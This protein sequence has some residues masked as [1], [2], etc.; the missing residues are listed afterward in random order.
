M[1]TVN[2]HIEAQSRRLSVHPFFTDLRPQPSLQQALVFA[3][4]LSPWVMSFQDV[5]RINAD[6]AVEPT[7]RRQLKQHAAEDQGHEAWFLEDLRMLFGDRTR[8]VAWLFGQETAVTR[9]ATLAIA[10]EAFRIGDDRLRLV[11]IDAI[12]AASHTFIEHVHRHVQESGDA[13]QLKYFGRT[14]E[15]AEAAHEMR[16]EGAE[17]HSPEM[18]LPASV[19]S[20]AIALV[21]RVFAEFSRMAESA[22]HSSSRTG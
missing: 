22:R 9:A 1:R 13:A 19:R 16:E 6:L 11:Y 5:I 3:P 14:H 18:D 8:D 15:Q 10:S 2:Q 7:I 4:V 20:D 17:W 12:E 21:D